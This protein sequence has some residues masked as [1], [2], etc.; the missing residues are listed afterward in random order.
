MPDNTFRPYA[1]VDKT[2]L[3]QVTL[4]EAHLI[5]MIREVPFG[6]V[7]VFKANGEVLRIEANKSI[8]LNDSAGR[9]LEYKVDNRPA[10]A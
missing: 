2:I 8:I 3:V 9:I 7:T 4:K 1:T 5:K 10:T 6:N